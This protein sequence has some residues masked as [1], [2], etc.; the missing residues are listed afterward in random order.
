[1]NVS[2]RQKYLVLSGVKIGIFKAYRE[3]FIEQ[4]RYGYRLYIGYMLLE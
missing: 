3:N 4:L 2:Q 1:M